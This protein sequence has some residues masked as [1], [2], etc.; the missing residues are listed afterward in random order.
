[1]FGWAYKL[2][3]P[4]KQVQLPDGPI[5]IDKELDKLG[6]FKISD[7]DIE[8]AQR[9]SFATGGTEIARIEHNDPYKII[10]Y[11]VIDEKQTEV[12]WI[13]LEDGTVKFGGNIDESAQALFEVFQP[14]VD[15]YLKDKIRKINRLD[16][17]I[18]GDLEK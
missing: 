5:D 7:V 3:Y 14:L 10:F 1:M 6:E 12:G 9:F 13:D 2:L 18:R 16:E 8:A 15:N 17:M 4:M 11:R